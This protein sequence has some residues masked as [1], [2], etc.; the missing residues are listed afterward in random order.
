MNE[1]EIITFFSWENFED[2]KESKS[3]DWFWA[4]GIIA[5]TS[6]VASIIYANYLFAVLILIAAGL[7]AFI[8]K[9]KP[10]REFYSVTNKGVKHNETFY[11]YKNIKAF[12]VDFD[13][14]PVSI[15]FQVERSFMPFVSFPIPD[16]IPADE[17]RDHVR[18][19]VE[20]KPIQEPKLHKI[21]ERIG[22]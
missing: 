8:A 14:E 16:N 15:L 10:E 5:V 6:V 4:L 1:K 7:L 9:K 3:K 11:P 17:L 18:E 20:E 12:W 22:L 2:K 13:D 21:L 19:Y